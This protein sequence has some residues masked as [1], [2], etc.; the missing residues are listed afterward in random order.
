[1]TSWFF[2]IDVG[3]HESEIH[4]LSLKS[5]NRV[6]I[7]KEFKVMPVKMESFHYLGYLFPGKKNFNFPFPDSSTK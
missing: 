2:E 5:G 1:M 6:Y 7:L 3:P 4:A